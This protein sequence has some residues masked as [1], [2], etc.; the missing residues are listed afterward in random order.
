MSTLTMIILLYFLLAYHEGFLAKLI[1]LMPTL[2]DK[3]R[4]V[5]IAHEIE[6]QI[7]RYLFTITLIN[8][9]LGIAV[10]TAVGSSA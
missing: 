6:A 10:G 2:S 5:T 8:L 3:K 4:T 9:C 1:K 7:S